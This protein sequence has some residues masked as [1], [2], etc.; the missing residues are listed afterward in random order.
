MYGNMDNVK[1][2]IEQDVASAIL[3][4]PEEVKVGGR[5][6]RVSPP[7]TATLILASAIISRLPQGKLD[8][9]HVMEETLS[10]AKDCASL[11]DLAAVLILGAKEYEEGARVCEKREKRLLWGLIRVRYTVRESLAE[12]LLR[13][14]T[15]REFQNLI[16]Q[17]L[18]RMQVGDF[19]ALT[20][21]LTEINLLRPTK[22][23][24]TEA[25]A[26]GR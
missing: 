14:T 15:P 3:E 22:V 19:F 10:V 4:R 13:E 23:V 1:K 2:T 17:L 16:V 11:G 6:Y 18:Q 25:T 26:S 9:G 8:G 21:F 20:T 24:E 5:T 12:R 7:S